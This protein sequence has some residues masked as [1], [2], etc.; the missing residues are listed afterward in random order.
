MATVALTHYIDEKPCTP[1]VC[2]MKLGTWAGAGVRIFPRDGEITVVTAHGNYVLKK[3]STMNLYS[4]VCGGH[5][6]RVVLRPMVGE[7]TWW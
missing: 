4:G 5:K 2:D 7:M 6:V 3:H 1:Q